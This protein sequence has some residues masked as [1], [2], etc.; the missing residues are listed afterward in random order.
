MAIE[1]D[2]ETVSNGI[3]QPDGIDPDCSNS[4]CTDLIPELSVLAKVF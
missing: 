2:E 1:E 4:V 3:F